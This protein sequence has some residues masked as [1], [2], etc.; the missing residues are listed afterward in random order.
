MKNIKIG[1]LLG[2]IGFTL[3]S[4]K[5]LV[6]DEWVVPDKYKAMKNPTDPTSK[7][8]LSLGKSLYSQQ[9]QACHGKQGY[10]DGLKAK[11]LKGDLGDFSSDATQ[12]LT[13][14]AL[15]YKITKGREDMPVFEK[16]LPLAEDRWLIVNYLR[17]LKE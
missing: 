10:G 2:V 3:Y 15:F 9:C 6:Q 5:T 8:N 14:G 17:T 4:F 16:K 12:S 1:I 13:D 7:K 11:G